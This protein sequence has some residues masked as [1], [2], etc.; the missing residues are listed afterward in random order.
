MNLHLTSTPYTLLQYA[1]MVLELSMYMLSQLQSSVCAISLPRRLPLSP[2]CQ[3]TS[4]S[5][6]KSLLKGKPPQIAKSEFTIL[7]AST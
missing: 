6:S 5:P 7:C 2:A 3:Q 1:V 4:F